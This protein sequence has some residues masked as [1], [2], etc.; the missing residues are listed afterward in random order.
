MVTKPNPFDRKSQEEEI[1]AF[2]EWSWTVEK[3]LSSVDEA[4][5][6]DLKEIRDKPDESFDMDLA[7]TQ[8]KTT[9]DQVHQAHGLLASL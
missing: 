2:R 7:T 1:K 4:Y 3:C 5:M 6:R 9:K 8:Q